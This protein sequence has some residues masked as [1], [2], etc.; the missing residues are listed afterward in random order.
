MAVEMVLACAGAL[1][2]AVGPCQ[3]LHSSNTDST[4]FSEF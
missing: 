2:H 3:V 4:E 1:H